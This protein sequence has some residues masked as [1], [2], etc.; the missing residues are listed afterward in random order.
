MKDL[1]DLKNTRHNSSAVKNVVIETNGQ[2]PH[3]PHG[4]KLSAIY[5][6]CHSIYVILNQPYDGAISFLPK[7]AVRKCLHEGFTKLVNRDW[8]E[9]CWQAYL[10][11]KNIKEEYGRIRTL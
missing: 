8:V 10:L 9:Q 3:L 1:F 2:F 6:E 4:T 5:I 11:Q 7:H